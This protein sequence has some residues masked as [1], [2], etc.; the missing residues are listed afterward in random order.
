MTF[1]RQAIGKKGE[2]EAARELERMGC[3]ILVRNYRCR[4]GEIDLIGRKGNALIFVEVRTRTSS[5]FG[6]PQESVNFRK[7]EKVRRV[8]QCFLAE[9]GQ[10]GSQISFWV[11]AVLM[12]R[13]GKVE[14][15]EVFEDAF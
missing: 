11:A 13:N 14:N 10:F 4:L 5:N 9:A 3:N 2:E 15:I 7:Q 6:L 8:A 1:L 12:G